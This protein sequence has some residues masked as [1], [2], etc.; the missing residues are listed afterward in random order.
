VPWIR[1][2]AAL[3]AATLL[4][5]GCGGSGGPSAEDYAAAGNAAC[6]RAAERAADVQRP[7]ADSAEAVSSYATAMLPIARDRLA[8]L[9]GLEPADEQ[10]RFH[11]RLLVEQERFV[12]AVETVGEAAGRQDRM[13]AQRAF[14]E[15]STASTRS[16]LLFRELGLGRCAESGF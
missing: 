15:G 9:R 8:A 14:Q 10:R 4:A 12:A 6:A 5:G 11:E 2:A 7:T 13:T 16:R 3:A 1:K